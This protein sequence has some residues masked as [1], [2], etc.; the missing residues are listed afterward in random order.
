[1]REPVFFGANGRKNSSQ[2][3]KHNPWEGQRVLIVG[4]A[5]SG[6]ALAQ[7]LCREKA[8]VTVNDM[9]PM[10]NFGDKLDALKA[11]PVEFR[12]GENGL[13]A[14]KEKEMLI[15]SP[16]VPIDAPIVK[17]AKEMGVAVSGELEIASRLTKGSMVA[18]TGTNGKTT[19]V[20]LLGA[21]FEQAGKS[22]MWLGISAI[23][24]LQPPWKAS[25]TM[26]WSWRYPPS[27]W[28][29]PILSIP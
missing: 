11:L 25:M 4:L 3:E 14:L 8:I 19:T 28:K 20:S 5:R 27:S 15:I 29:P 2:E 24:Y 1:M 21:I 13:D 22:A 7:L 6:I 26:R 23:P 12:L 18:V 17:A 16:G 10:E 9:K